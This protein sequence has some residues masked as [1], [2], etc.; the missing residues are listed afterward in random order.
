MFYR[1]NQ[2]QLYFATGLFDRRTAISDVVYEPPI[3]PHD[4]VIRFYKVCKKW[5]NEVKKNPASVEEQRL[6]E[7]SEQ[8]RMCR[9]I[10]CPYAR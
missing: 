1:T 7:N 2:S 6:F 10:S 5:Q 4:P 9:I 3:N 8:V